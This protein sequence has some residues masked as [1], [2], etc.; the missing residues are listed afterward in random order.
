[1]EDKV[2]DLLEKVYI[3]LQ[4][5]KKD[6]KSVNNH[7]IRL[8]DE[9]HNKIGILSDEISLMRDDISFIKGKVEVIEKKVD[10][11]GMKIQ[12]IEGGKKK[13]SL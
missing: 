7:I 9:F 8:E 12:V 2:F 13:K 5:N 3:D 4:E 11:H 10:A 1:M 6:V